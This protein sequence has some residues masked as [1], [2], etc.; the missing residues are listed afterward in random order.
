MVDDLL[1]EA[2]RKQL[3]EFYSEKGAANQ[4]EQ[5][6]VLA[7]KLSDLTKREAFSGDEIHT[8][9]QT[10]GVKTPKNL[11][12]VFGNMTADGLGNMADKK[13][14]PNFKC[15]DLVKHD[16]PRKTAKK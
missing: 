3:R 7:F 14:K 1:E 4:N 16:L 11:M 12:A 10:V 2:Q 13:F 8:A 6:A 5:V 15:D 9:F